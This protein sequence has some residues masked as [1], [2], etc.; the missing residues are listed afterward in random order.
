MDDAC[1]TANVPGS[2]RC[3]RCKLPVFKTEGCNHITCRCG[4]HWCYVCQM[5]FDRSGDVYEHMDKEHGDW[6][7]PVEV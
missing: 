6:F 1:N 3:P 5:G 7:L 4:C 2:K